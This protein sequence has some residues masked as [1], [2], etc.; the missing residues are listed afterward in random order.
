MTKKFSL[1]HGYNSPPYWCSTVSDIYNWRV[2]EV[3]GEKIIDI[4]FAPLIVPK[5][6]SLPRLIGDVISEMPGCQKYGA[7]LGVSQ[8]TQAQQGSTVYVDSDSD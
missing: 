6:R 4:L 3:S 7:Y 2:I 1:A 8:D 5:Q